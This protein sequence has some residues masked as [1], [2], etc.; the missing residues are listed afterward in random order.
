MYAVRMDGQGF[1]AVDGIDDL[2][3]GE[4]LHEELPPPDAART[5]VLADLDV[6]RE[7]AAIEAANPISQGDLRDYLVALLPD[8]HPDKARLAGVSAQVAALRARIE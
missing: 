5:K 3:A 4:T 8:K 6:E 1:R 2:L 7:I